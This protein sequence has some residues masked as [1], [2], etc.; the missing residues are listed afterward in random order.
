MK[1]IRRRA[2]KRKTLKQLHFTNAEIKRMLQRNLNSLEAS[3]NQK[4]H[5]K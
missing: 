1:R 4:R 3:Y 5:L 2:A